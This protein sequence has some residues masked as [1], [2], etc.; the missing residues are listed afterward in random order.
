MLRDEVGAARTVHGVLTP[1]AAWRTSGVE[2]AGRVLVLG[3]GFSRA[4]SDV[5]PL[6]D[7]LGRLVVRDLQA[8]GLSGPA[9]GFKGGYFEAWLSRLAEP[10]PD[11]REWENLANQAWFSR[12]TEQVRTVLLREQRVVLSDAAPGWLM[13][14]VAVLHRTRTTVVTF[15][16]DLLLEAALN[17]AVLAGP[18][19][20]GRPTSHDATQDLPPSPP[21]GGRSL[22]RSA[23]PTFPLLK[24][25][26]SVDC[27]W[28][29]G[30][31]TGSTIVREAGLAVFGR[32]PVPGAALRPPGRSPFIV[33]PASGK[34]RFYANPV[35]RELWQRA[36]EAIGG[37]A[38]VDLVGCSLPPS[39]LVTTGM[40]ADRLARPDVAVRVVNPSPDAPLAALTAAGVAAARFDGGVPALVDDLEA[41]LAA[42]AWDEL[43]AIGAAGDVEGAP[44]L[45]GPAPHWSR[46]V[47]GLSDSGALLVEDGA[48]APNPTRARRD[49]DPTPLTVRD[50]RAL[51]RAG[52]PLTVARDGTRSAVIGWETRAEQTGHRNLWVVAIT[53]AAG[54][55]QTA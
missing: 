50:L 5:M 2:P 6:T 25:H 44:V 43:A 41:R 7:D 14:L 47:V 24:L 20:T 38:A 19:G 11:L 22:S 17:S 12:I 49:N 31:A 35:T 15:N 52:A 3:A 13:R 30:D 54:A 32:D 28:V 45:A 10:Q 42:A 53:A 37:A 21:G 55:A 34:S 8:E 1:R 33:P 51:R 27:W 36:A 4:V 46:A 26:G 29:G 9:G 16:Y 23:V 39:D 40:L 18:E 48:E